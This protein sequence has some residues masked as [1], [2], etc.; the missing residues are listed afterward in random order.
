MRGS[1]SKKHPMNHAVAPPVAPVDTERSAPAR[2]LRAVTVTALVLTLAAAGHTA[3]GGGLPS[4]G[5]LAGVGLAVLVPVSWACGRRLSAARLLLLLGTA[6][7][8]L[9]HVLTALAAAATCPSAAGGHPH[10]GLH[11]RVIGAA[12]DAGGAGGCLAHLATA[13]HHQAAGTGAAMPAGHVVAVALTA[14]GLARIEKI[15][16]WLLDSLDPLVALPAPA[17]VP[18]RPGRPI[19]PPPRRPTRTRRA[20]RVH[21]VR[22]P[23]ATPAPGNSC[24]TR[25]RTRTPVVPAPRHRP[26]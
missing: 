12:G 22:G 7:L 9:H 6:Q 17:T 2:A 11:E 26:T 14:V 25:L 10:R 4:A 23:P 21:P 20:P 1:S 15:L 24:R 13:G 5:V 16:W 8:V 3:G 19:A 18:A